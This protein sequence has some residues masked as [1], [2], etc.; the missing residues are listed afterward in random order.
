M[1]KGF[2]HENRFALCSFVPTKGK[3]LL[4]LPRSRHLWQFLK[5]I[6]DFSP[7]ECL[8]ILMSARS[9]ESH[10]KKTLFSAIIKSIT[11]AC[12]IDFSDIGLASSVIDMVEKLG[13]KAKSD[14]ISMKMLDRARRKRKSLLEVIFEMEMEAIEGIEK[15]LPIRA[16]Q[17][18]DRQIKN[19][20][21]CKTDWN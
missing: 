3:P 13:P 17:N 5:L 6:E 11:E 4:F 14:R 1:I 19:L 16:E 12:S 21:I 7:E 8:E 18:S 9:K 20:E 2:N 10:S 15:F